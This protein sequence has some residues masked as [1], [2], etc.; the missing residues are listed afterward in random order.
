[1]TPS[2][3]PVIRFRSSSFRSQIP[4]QWE[5]IVHMQT[6]DAGNIRL[7]VRPIKPSVAIR[8]DRNPALLPARHLMSAD[9]ETRRS[10]ER[11]WTFPSRVENRP[12]GPNWPTSTSVGT[13]ERT[14]SRPR[15]ALLTAHAARIQVRA[16]TERFFERGAETRLF[17][18]LA[19]VN[20]GRRG[21]SPTSRRR[22][23]SPIV[24]DT[25]SVGI[26]RRAV[27]Q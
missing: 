26:R 7:V 16:M 1:M 17:N 10:R 4:I 23:S 12:V 27:E 8:T 13:S 5:R 25:G 14:A 19:S 6:G 21:T 24:F 2:T 11:G 15:I 20:A 18:E 9:R 22:S 3:D